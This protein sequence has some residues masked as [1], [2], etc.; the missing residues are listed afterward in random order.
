MFNVGSIILFDICTY[1]IFTLY[2]TIASVMRMLNIY[3]LPLSG[4]SSWSKNYDAAGGKRQSPIDIDTKATK[5]KTLPDLAI[6]YDPSRCTK[7]LNN[8]HTFTVQVEERD[9]SKAFQF[10]P[11][12]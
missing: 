4:P 9:T 5:P 8:G 6:N 1:C 7:I 10:T 11:I 12:L 2:Y 3:S